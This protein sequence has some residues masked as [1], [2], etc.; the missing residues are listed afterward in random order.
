[1]TIL[2]GLSNTNK[3]FFAVGTTVIM[4]YSV[5]LPVRG[6]P[7]GGS[8]LAKVLVVSRACRKPGVMPIILLCLFPAR[9]IILHPSRG[10]EMQSGVFASIVFKPDHTPE[11]P[12]ATP[13]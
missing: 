2:Q 1:M 5:V 10:V 8:F 9:W 13:E 3:G 11:I 6:E 7:C 12:G 4:A